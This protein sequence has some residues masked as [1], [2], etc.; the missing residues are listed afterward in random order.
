VQPIGKCLPISIGVEPVE[1]ADNKGALLLCAS[2]KSACIWDL[3]YWCLKP[4]PSALYK[5]NAPEHEATVVPGCR[6]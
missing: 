4:R 2:F 6:P 1:V 3:E 5:F